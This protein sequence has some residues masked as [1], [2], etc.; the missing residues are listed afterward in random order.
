MAV[1][2]LERLGLEDRLGT[3]SCEMIVDSF[4]SGVVPFQEANEGVTSTQV[5]R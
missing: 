2:S 5:R 4:T 3:D 1:R